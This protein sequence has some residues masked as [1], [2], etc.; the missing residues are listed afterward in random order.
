MNHDF[1]LLLQKFQPGVTHFT[2]ME[3]PD[4][5]FIFHSLFTFHCDGVYF[6]LIEGATE[7]N[8]ICFRMWIADQR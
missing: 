2:G 6:S 5:P 7:T 3:K 8:L 1:Q 4:A